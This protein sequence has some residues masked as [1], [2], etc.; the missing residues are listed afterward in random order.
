MNEA[1]PHPLAAWESFYVIVGTSGGALIGIQ[2]VVITL[3]ASIRRRTNLDTVDAFATPTVVHFAAALVISAFM[4]APWHSLAVPSLGLIAC[5]FFG[6]VYGGLIIR[7]AFRQTE[8]K[9]V[10]EDWIWY[11]IAPFVLYAAIMLGA[12]FLPGGSEYSAFVIA[13]AVL[14]LLLVGIHNA[15][16]TVT[17][18]VGMGTGDDKDI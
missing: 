1:V 11:Q 7:R 2:F 5:G 14:S 18:I 8:Y 10:L 12:L 9:P 17:H 3:I 13:T 6:L 15:W 16:D 4:S